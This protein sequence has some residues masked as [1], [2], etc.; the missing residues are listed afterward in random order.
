MPGGPF[1]GE[2]AAVD[3]GPRTATVRATSRLRC[4]T[5]REGTLPAFLARHPRVAVNM[6][7]EVARR[8]RDARGTSPV[9]A[10]LG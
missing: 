6:L 3:G 4:L 10:G 7:T 9:P 2:I 5:L 8:F 1:F